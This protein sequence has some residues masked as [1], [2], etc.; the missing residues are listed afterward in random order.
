MGNGYLKK[1]SKCG[2]EITIIEGIGMWDAPC[3][4]NIPPSNIDSRWNDVIKDKR[5]IKEI[6]NIIVNYNG[7]LNQ[8][9]LNNEESYF[10]Y[11]YG[12]K[13]Y[14]SEEENVIY[15]LF[16]FQLKYIE[17]EIIKI[18]EPIYYDKHK[19]PLRL[20]KEDENINDVCPKCGSE[21]EMFY[22]LICWD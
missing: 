21:F 15:N 8:I 22:G 4:Y 2:H 16:H 1:C 7:E 11:V 5:I 14:Y 17:K 13:E 6:E 18:Y 12:W 3:Y 9:K 20:L 19:K 10:P